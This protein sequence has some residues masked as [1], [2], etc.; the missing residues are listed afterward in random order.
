MSQ[1]HSLGLKL[2]IYEDFGTHTCGGYPGSEYH[3]ESD[4]NTF[5]EWGVDYLKLDGCYSIPAQYNDGMLEVLFTTFSVFTYISLSPDS[6]LFKAHRAAN[7]IE[8]RIPTLS[9]RLWNQGSLVSQSK[10][11]F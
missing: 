8:L 1:V 6:V 7:S 4:A 3:L 11:V 2:G 10:A 5:A 9:A